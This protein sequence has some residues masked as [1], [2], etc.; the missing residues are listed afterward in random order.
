MAWTKHPQCGT[1]EKQK[2]AGTAPHQNRYNFLFIIC[3]SDSQPPRNVCTVPRTHQV[4]KKFNT[5]F[6]FATL[7]EFPSPPFGR[8][9]LCAVCVNDELVGVLE[10][11]TGKKKPRAVPLPYI[12][13][14]ISVT[15]TRNDSSQR[16]AVPVRYLIRDIGSQQEGSASTVAEPWLCTGYI[17]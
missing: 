15:Y 3:I 17:F 11:F 12:R 7:I 6:F 16:R 2:A 8:S 9:R 4:D 14:D 1:R 5:R 13:N 10:I